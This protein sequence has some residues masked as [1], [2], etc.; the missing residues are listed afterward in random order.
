MR[1]QDRK[2]NRKPPQHAFP[3][4]VRYLNKVFD[5]RARTDALRDSRH[6]PDISPAAVFRA[7]FYGFV[8]RLSSFQQLESDL[9]DS[10][11]QRWMGVDRAFRDDVLR[12]SLCGFDLAALE[13]MLVQINRTLKRNKAL[14]AGRVQGRIVAALDGVEVLSSYS[15][16]CEYCQERVIKFPQPD[17]SVEERTQYYHQA[18]GCQIVSSPI[19]PILGLEWRRP[20]EGED[21][22]ARR[23]LTR[24]VELYGGR[25]FDILLL[26][27][28]YPQAPLLRLTQEVG[29]DVVISLKQ[30][31][32]DLYQDAMGL[33]Q[34]RGADLEFEQKEEDCHRQVQLWQATD[35]PFSGDYPLPMRVVRSQEQVARQRI[36]GGQSYTAITQQEWCWISTLETPAFPA[37]VV[38]SLGHLRWKNE[39]NGWNDLSQN[40]A[41]KHGFLHACKH[42]PKTLSAEGKR[43]PVANRGL[44]VVAL[45]RCLA[46]NLFSAFV[47]LHSKLFRRYS[48]VVAE[49]A[50]QLRRSCWKS[51]PSIRSPA[52]SPASV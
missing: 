44:A 34:A 15:R 30:Q 33:F 16:C 45:I 25:F 3:S 18:V 27:S 11:V 52:P 47:R 50:R 6:Q 28:L 22:C 9:A 17:G 5:F 23:L 36:R 32:R 10:A 19:K 1:R 8:F 26:D 49:V 29:W 35:L 51:P 43:E 14:E 48:L 20:G 37:R 46:F 2:R 40:F 38:W 24:L 39:N 13:A 21:T 12:Y 7:V 31:R 4:F 42:R 41:L